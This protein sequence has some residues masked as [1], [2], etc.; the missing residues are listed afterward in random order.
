MWSRSQG[1]SGHTAASP[2]VTGRGHCCNKLLQLLKTPRGLSIINNWFGFF[3][4]LVFIPCPWNNGHDI[5]EKS[6]YPQLC[7]GFA[8]LLNLSVVTDTGVAECSIRR[9]R[10]PRIPVTGAPC[11]PVMTPTWF[12]HRI[13]LQFSHPSQT[14]GLSP[15]NSVI[16]NH[17]WQMGGV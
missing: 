2:T 3:S 6:G 11:P 10:A 17:V 9:R 4:P 8:D 13:P 15:I 14:P 16:L 5:S 12:L 7:S 1:C